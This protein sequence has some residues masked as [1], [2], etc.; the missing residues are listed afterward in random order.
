MKKYYVQVEQVKKYEIEIDDSKISLEDLRNFEEVMY[1][2]DEIDDDKYA[3]FAYHIARNQA[4]KLDFEGMGCPLI[5]GK[6]YFKPMEN[7]N[8]NIS[9]L[10]EDYEDIEVVEINS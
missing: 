3:S 9:L 6:S 7:E 10:D 4:N 8:I 2:L 5:N 1:D